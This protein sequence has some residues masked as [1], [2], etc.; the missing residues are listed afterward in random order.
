MKSKRAREAA[1]TAEE[2][3]HVPDAVEEQ[4]AK[5]RKTDGDEDSGEVK[6]KKAKDK[7]DKKDKNKKESR[8]EKKDKRKDLQDLPEEDV[9]EDAVM[10]EAAPVEVTEEKKDKKSKKSKRDKEVNGESKEAEGEQEPKKDKKDKKSKK[11]KEAEGEKEPKND[12]NDKKD[13]KDKKDKD[14]KKSKK[15]KTAESAA[16]DAQ[17]PTPDA[18]A[19][20]DAA[21]EAEGKTDRHIVFVGNLPYTA[22][23]ATISAHFAS[24]AP[25]SVRCLTKKEDAGVCRGIAFV[26]FANVWTMRTCLD[27]F[28]HSLFDDGKS[29]ARKIN[30]E[31]TAGGGGK[32]KHRS[33]KIREKNKKLDENRAKRIEREKT[34]KEEG[35][36]KHQ[37]EQHQ[38]QPP[39]ISE[40]IHPSRLA[41]NPLLRH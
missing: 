19:D 12:K 14:K 8:K 13:K 34:A 18:D 37:Q 23:S 20:A 1:A 32:T 24:L 25:V 15:D 17:P 22:T 31:L 35:A 16:S 9:E 5:K 3:K 39:S 4:P 30:V 6:Q 10:A 41:R 2:E 36:G 7:K 38:L 28:H 40:S 11:G 21:Q 26:E 29:P 33:D 27:R